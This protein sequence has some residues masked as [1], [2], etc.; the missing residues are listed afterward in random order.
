MGGNPENMEPFCLFASNQGYITASMGYTLLIK[1]FQDFNIYRILDEVTECIKAIKNEL[2]KSGFKED[3]LILGIGGYSA[4]AHL[5][6]LYSYLIQNINII[7][8]KFVI[9]ICG[10]IGLRIKY[11]YKLKSGIKAFDEA[12]MKDIS[13][14]EKAKEDGIIIPT[15]PDM[16]D[17]IYMN[18]FYGNKYTDEEL[19]SMLYEN[20]TIN[21]EN[22]NYKK[23]EKF[24]KNAFVTEIEDKHKLPTLCVYGGIDEVVGVAAFAYLKQKMDKDKRPYDFV[25]SKTE[26]HLPIIP[27][28]KEGKEQLI[29]ISQ[30]IIEYFHKYFGY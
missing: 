30:K 19:N 9:N 7:P 13:A 26:G 8:I 5:A 25:Y 16:Q 2:I 12:V 4:G 15:F 14:I 11:F 22:E 24:D 29:K 28:S 18:A 10:P 23:M 21:Y 17:L 20:G 6:L 27:T 3:K 1:Y